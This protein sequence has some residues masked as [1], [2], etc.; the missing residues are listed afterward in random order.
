MATSINYTVTTHNP[1]DKPP[2]IF[3]NGVSGVAN[4]TAGL[5]AQ[6]DFIHFMT[7]PTGNGA[8]FIEAFD[9]TVGGIT[10]VTHSSTVSMH[11]NP[12]MNN[13]DSFTIQ[14]FDLGT[15]G[16]LDIIAHPL[17]LPGFEGTLTA[18]FFLHDVPTQSAPVPEP[19][20]MALLGL[21]MAGLAVY[22][23]RR[24]KKNEA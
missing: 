10:G 6:E 14:S 19:G 21:G 9:V 12:I 3:I 11:F 13:I 24:A 17:A 1:V 8:D 15:L 16:I 2:F 22:G 18:G 20:T 7:I 4:L 5:I 23:K